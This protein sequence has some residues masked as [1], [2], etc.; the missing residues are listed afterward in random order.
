MEK[1]KK[2][3]MMLPVLVLPFILL[4]C[5]ILGVG[6]GTSAD[7]GAA[8]A[9]GL[10]AKLP[11]AHFK[12]GK[13]KD[14]LGLYEELEK[15]SARIRMLLKK[16]GSDN[17]IR[18]I[19]L[20]SSAAS[21]TGN[22]FS[23][24]TNEEKI[25][26]KI[27]ILKRTLQANNGD[28]KTYH[29]AIP[30][31]SNPQPV[32]HSLP[33]KKEPDPELS[34]MNGMLDKIML[35]QHPEK[36]ADSLQANAAKNNATALTVTSNPLTANNASGFYGLDSVVN[37]AAKGNVIRAVV[38]ET[39]TLV[40][41]AVVRLRLLQGVYIGQ[42]LVPQNQYLYGVSTLRNDRLQISVASLRSGNDILPISL[43]VYDLDGLQGIYV[44]GSITRDA[45]K[46]SA[47]QAMGGLALASLDPSVG[48]QA[49]SAGIQAA[50]TLIGRKIKLVRVTVK[51]GYQVLLRNSGHNSY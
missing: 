31:F 27:S 47:D 15:D 20:K 23:R 18:D 25:M 50:K 3:L 10:N 14:K 45:S 13:E 5:L 33:I 39:Q 4:L 35:I 36:M 11:D 7:A 1:K 26:D 17:E 46:E 19:L 9:T 34:Q 21:H 41:G 30:D 44:P 22:L 12:K 24:D 51:S 49:A 32:I 42:I 38:E 8:A 16:D 48:A 40:S 43:D 37:N 2:F 6:K 29:Q 28:Q